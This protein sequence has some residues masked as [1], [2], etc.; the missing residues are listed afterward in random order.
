MSWILI[1][2]WFVL[3]LDCWMNS[4]G[5][6]TC[7]FNFNG[8]EIRQPKEITAIININASSTSKHSKFYSVICFEVVFILIEINE[9]VGNDE[10]IIQ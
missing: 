9:L 8:H 10:T 4:F 3:L 7:F 5:I 6:N 1:F 2:L